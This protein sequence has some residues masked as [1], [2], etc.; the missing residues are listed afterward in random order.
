MTGR[1]GHNLRVVEASFATAAPLT[2]H[3][4]NAQALQPGV[5]MPCAGARL[6]PSQSQLRQCDVLRDPAHIHME[7]IS[8]AG[9]QVVMTE[10]GEHRSVQLEDIIPASAACGTRSADSGPGSQHAADAGPPSSSSD[11]EEADG[12]TFQQQVQLLFHFVCCH[13]PSS[14]L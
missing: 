8:A 4:T 1:D 11:E 2:A 9:M 7:S 12:P 14:C 3:T 6:L 13:Q 10:T 5:I